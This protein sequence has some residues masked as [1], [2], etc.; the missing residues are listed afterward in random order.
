MPGNKIQKVAKEVKRDETAK[1]EKEGKAKKVAKAINDLTNNQAAFRKL[2][3][4]VDNRD[5]V[6]FNQACDMVGVPAEMKPYLMSIT[7][8]KSIYDAKTLG[9]ASYCWA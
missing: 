4:A 5:V 7:F 2:L 9:D 3:H 6:E 1:L 8:M